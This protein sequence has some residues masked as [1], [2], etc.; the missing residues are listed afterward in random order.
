MIS[1]RDL[2]F[3]YSSD[4]RLNIPALEIKPYEKVAIIGPSGSGKTTLL[5]LISGIAIPQA[6]EVRVNEQQVNLLS[7]Q[8][9]RDFRLTRMGFV[10]QNFELLDYLSV[11]ENVLL[12][13]RISPALQLNNEVR[14]RASELLKSMGMGDKQDRYTDLLSQGERQ[15]VAI[16]R[17]LLTNPPLILADEATGNLD[18]QNKQLIVD[19]LFDAVDKHNTTLVAVTHD[20]DLL[21]RFDRVVN[22]QDFRAEHQHD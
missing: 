6:G 10:F 15:R 13:Y 4:F 18:P 16:C 21:D 20:H 12:P 1:I 11:L 14:E 3:D 22:F 17:A 8:Q 7:D 9:R 5:N 19:L 2:Q